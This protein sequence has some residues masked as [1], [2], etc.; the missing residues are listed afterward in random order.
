[1]LGLKKHS[2]L[3]NRADSSRL[4]SYG[5]QFNLDLTIESLRFYRFPLIGSPIAP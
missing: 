2:I 3:G 1:L 5:L 4:G